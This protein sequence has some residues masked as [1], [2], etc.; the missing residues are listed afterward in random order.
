MPV[1]EFD[2]LCANDGELAELRASVRQFI[3]ADRAVHGW[4]PAIDSWLTS[5]D[6]GFSERLADAGYVGLTIPAEYGGHGR[7]FLHRYVVTEELLGQGA[8]VAAHWFADRQVAPA[9]LSYGSEEQRRRLLPRIAAGRL[10]SAIGMSEHGAGSDLAATATKATRT[11]AGWRLNGTSP[12][13]WP[14]PAPRTPSTGTPGS[15][16][17]SSCSTPPA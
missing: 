1:S 5:W 17:S 16:S 6:A 12:S 2:A 7:G 9:L 10:Y 14:A 13:C 15:A 8:P 4:Q 3:T 11:A